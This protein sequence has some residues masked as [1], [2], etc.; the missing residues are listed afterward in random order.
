MRY[1]GGDNEY[2]F[3][4]TLATLLVILLVYGILF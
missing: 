4:V 1:G 3:T 2:Q